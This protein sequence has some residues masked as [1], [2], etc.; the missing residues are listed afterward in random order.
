MKQN[1][2]ASVSE[3]SS[4]YYSDFYPA[5]NYDFNY[6]N[7]EKFKI[8]KSIIKEL[9]I[10]I[11]SKPEETLSIE[12]DIRKQS[13]FS[14]N[15]ILE[16]KFFV[17]G[18]NLSGKTSFCL[19]FAKNEFNLEIKPS[20]EINCYLK[21]LILF[22]KEIKVYLIDI[23]E[24]LINNY[25]NLNNL[26]YSDIKGVFALYDITNIKSLDN[27]LK[28]IENLRN[29]IGNVIPIILVGNKNDLNNLK[30]IDFEDVKNKSKKYKCILKE[31]NC[32]EENSV[33]EI[34]KYFLANIYYNDLDEL[35]KDKIK[36][37]IIIKEKRKKENNQ[38]L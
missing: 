38:N 1:D 3:D 9:N 6:N 33:N 29:K 36:N 2:N 14:K 15:N 26:L 5:D 24:N 34:V 35:E 13:L 20:K 23:N 31:G 4:S 32:I 21:T 11:I 18:D 16:Y 30:R 10:K 22:D 27:T 8:Y 37:D 7:S 12:K 25:K 19:K 28:L 17:I